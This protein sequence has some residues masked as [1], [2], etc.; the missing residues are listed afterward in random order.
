M[1][2]SRR[3]YAFLLILFTFTSA[4]HVLYFHHVV[5]LV[6]HLSEQARAPFQSSGTVVSS[7]EREAAAARIREGDTIEDI[8]GTPFVGRRVLDQS[9]KGA[10]PGSLLTAAIRRQDGTTERAPLSD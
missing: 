5:R 4:Y 6:E 3:N 1:P 8:G 9:L 10:R 7:V 2:P